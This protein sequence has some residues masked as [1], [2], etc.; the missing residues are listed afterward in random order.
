[1]SPTQYQTFLWFY[2]AIWS[3]FMAFLI[4]DFVALAPIFKLIW[5]IVYNSGVGGQFGDW[6]LY[7]VQTVMCWEIISCGCYSNTL[8]TIGIKICRWAFVQIYSWNVGVCCKSWGRQGQRFATN[9]VCE[10]MNLYQHSVA[11]LYGY[12]IAG[13]SDK[14]VLQLCENDTKIQLSNGWWAGTWSRLTMCSEPR[15]GT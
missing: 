12:Y 13:L 14:N 9:T 10:V 1:M 8:Y 6:R 5:Y 4:N 7:W 2:I 11:G 15:P 3:C